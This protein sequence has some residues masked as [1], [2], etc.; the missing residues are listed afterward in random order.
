MIQ[1]H[2]QTAKHNNPLSQLLNPYISL[3]ISIILILKNR[4]GGGKCF[5]GTSII[6][7]Q[8]KNRISNPNPLPPSPSSSSSLALLE[9]RC[10]IVNQDTCKE[11]RQM[12]A[13]SKCGVLRMFAH[14][15]NAILFFVIL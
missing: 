6:P 7:L 9:K 8:F 4:C 10:E 12:R 5:D 11:V 2:T 13:G 14:E 3:H 15:V 1:I